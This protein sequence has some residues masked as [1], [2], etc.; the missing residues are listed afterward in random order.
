MVK[1]IEGEIEDHIPALIGHVHPKQKREVG[2]HSFMFDMSNDLLRTFKTAEDFMAASL[3][4]QEYMF[5]YRR[6]PAEKWAAEEPC[7]ACLLTKVV[8]DSEM[9]SAILNVSHLWNWLNPYRIASDG[10]S[11]PSPMFVFLE[12]CLFQ[13]NCAT[14]GEV[15]ER[16]QRKIYAPANEVKAL[17]ERAEAAGVEREVI[18]FAASAEVQKEIQ[19]RQTIEMQQVAKKKRTEKKAR[20]RKQG[21]FD[22][23]S[24]LGEHFDRSSGIPVTKKPPRASSIYSHRPSFPPPPA[25]NPQR[26]LPDLSSFILGSFVLAEAPKRRQP[27]T[28][29]TRPTHPWRLLNESQQPAESQADI[30]DDIEEVIDSYASSKHRPTTSFYEPELNFIDAYLV[31]SPSLRPDCPSQPNVADLRRQLWTLSMLDD[32]PPPLVVSHSK[33]KMTPPW[34]TDVVEPSAYEL[35]QVQDVARLRAER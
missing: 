13:L 22:V 7:D 16:L 30:S 8:R 2:E 27:L 4:P 17:V 10:D 31:L 19:R 25:R 15:Q 6:A 23:G 35:E 20:L 21:H 9:L 5:N 24:L 14:T 34:A 32:M 26:L 18:N 33:P 29:L 28:C 11:Q 3:V 1:L 12:E